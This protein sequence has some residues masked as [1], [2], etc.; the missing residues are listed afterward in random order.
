MPCHAMPRRPTHPPTLSPTLPPTPSHHTVTIKSPTITHTWSADC[1]L[2]TWRSPLY[3]FS[4]ND[5]AGLSEPHA[6]DGQVSCFFP[7]PATRD[8]AET[9]VMP[10]PVNRH[11]YPQGS[12]QPVAA[13]HCRGMHSRQKRCGGG[14][15]QN[16]A[17]PLSPV[18][19]RI[20]VRCRGGG[21]RI[22]KGH[23]VARKE[24]ARE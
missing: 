6:G 12:M 17:P 11:V 14:P 1:L 19:A 5:V 13:V 10:P 7:L 8:A 22:R 4:T 18:A 20:N 15:R 24:G 21:R 16:Q 9:S 23:V 2:S 3:S